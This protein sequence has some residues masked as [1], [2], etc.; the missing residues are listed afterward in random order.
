[1]KFLAAS[2]SLIAVAA[3]LPLN[4]TYT[5]P[6]APQTIRISPEVI[7]L[8]HISTGQVEYNV[9]A[10]HIHRA[11]NSGD[12]LSTLATF[13]IDPSYSGKQCSFG[14]DVDNTV[15]FDPKPAFFDVFTSQMPAYENKASWPQGNLRDQHVGRMKLSQ[16]PGEATFEAGQPT[17]A[18]LFP[19]YTGYIAGELVP[20]G[21]VEDVCFTPSSTAGPY[22]QVHL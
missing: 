12:D 9:A 13:Y 2:A 18:K 19:C 5:T 1:M 7:S 8:Y 16:Q 10:G 20:V 11:Q 14:F 3:A 17:A 15:H 21:D 4:G 22:I 6:T